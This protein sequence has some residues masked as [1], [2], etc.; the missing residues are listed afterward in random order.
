MI[1]SVHFVAKNVFYVFIFD[2]MQT[3]QFYF[4]LYRIILYPY[5]RTI[6]CY[7]AKNSY[8]T[9]TRIGQTML[10]RHGVRSAYFSIIRSSATDPRLSAKNEYIL[11]VDI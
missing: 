9:Y 3:L 2:C 6:P 7:E 10:V 8:T 11:A 1:F 4:V 5:H